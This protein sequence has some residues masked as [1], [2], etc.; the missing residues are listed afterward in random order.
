MI[1]KQI[2]PKAYDLPYLAMLFCKKPYM[3]SLILLALMAV[4]GKLLKELFPKM[5]SKKGVSIPRENRLN[6]IESV[7]KRLYQAICALYSLI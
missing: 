1:N 4:T 2:Q 7:I 6:T 3:T 5:R